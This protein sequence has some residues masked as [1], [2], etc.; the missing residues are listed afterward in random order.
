MTLTNR[1]H[2]RAH[3]ILLIDLN[4]FYCQV[5]E[6]CD[7]SIV[8]KPVAVYQKNYVVTSNYAARDLHVYKGSSVREAKEICPQLILKNGEDLTNYRKASDAF[9]SILQELTY[10]TETTVQK[11]GLDEVFLDITVLS[12]LCLRYLL[13]LKK[14]IVTLHQEQISLVQRFLSNHF[15][16]N[17]INN[18]SV[19]TK[20]CSAIPSTPK[21]SFSILHVPFTYR[22]DD[23]LQDTI[24]LEEEGSR[25]SV[26]K[27]SNF[28]LTCGTHICDQLRHEVYSRL[29]L[30][31]SAGI[32]GSKVVAK[33]A[34]KY[35]QKPNTQ[36]VV[37]SSVT[38]QF[39][40]THQL[41]DI[42]R[43][44]RVT[45][46]SLK[47]H[48]I[49]SIAEI[50]NY[51]VSF[52]LNIFHGNRALA[53]YLPL[54]CLGKDILV[55]PVVN[56]EVPKSI[57]VEDSFSIQRGITNENQLFY[58][59][60]M[61]TYRLVKRAKDYFQSYQKAPTTLKVA[62]KFYRQF[63]RQSRQTT[64][65]RLCTTMLTTNDKNEKIVKI[66]F[67]AAINILTNWILKHSLI[68]TPIHV[69]N[70]CLTNFKH[71]PQDSTLRQ[72][73]QTSKTT[74]YFQ[75]TRIVKRSKRKSREENYKKYSVF[76]SSMTIV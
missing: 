59:V 57:S 5:E 23:N 29:K 49:T 21:D 63:N 8:G 60:K 27:Q 4:C 54:A 26:L 3:V 56:S 40:Q 9:F 10:N 50:S 14:K 75:L 65:P 37:Y 16:S 34:S 28:L 45:I 48:G 15:I 33:L 12:K 7:V 43:L 71:L 62:V 58:T 52:F 67:H 30:C 25:K 44:G 72:F 74:S 20:G 18:S 31:T 66:F 24:L 53:E 47:E 17:I 13:E 68:K 6:L 55:D 35:L 19:T 70:L 36:L 76:K 22:F 11:V 1:F 42:P 51:S 38:P 46:S 41:C 61:L 73:I 39:I 69:V 64:L 32:G 2:D